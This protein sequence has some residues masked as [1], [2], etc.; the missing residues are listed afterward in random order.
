MSV[1]AERSVKGSL[2]AVLGW[3][4]PRDPSAKA[5]LPRSLGDV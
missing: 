4:L 5:L 1:R 3:W 2:E